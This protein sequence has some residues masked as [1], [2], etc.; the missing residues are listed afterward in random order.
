MILCSASAFSDIELAL[1]DPKWE[2]LLSNNPFG[3]TS[4]QVPASESA[5]AQK[6]QPLLAEKNHQAILD[7]FST[8][9]VDKDSAALRQLRGQMLLSMKRNDEAKVALKKAL[10]LMPDL[11]TAHQSLSMVYLIDKEYRKAREHLSRAIELGASNAELYGQL[12]FVHTQLNQPASAIAG[13]QYALFLDPD[14]KHWQ[15]GLLFALSSA[16]AYDQ[17]L[18]LIE[19]MLKKSPRDAQLWLRRGQLA[20]AQD[21]KLMA[22]SSMEAALDLGENNVANIATT[23][24]LHLQSGS[25][26]RAVTLLSD[27]MN[28]FANPDQIES[29]SQIAGWFAYQ[30][31]WEKLNKLIVAY[32]DFDKN[33]P[34]SYRAQFEVYQA[35][36]A[37]AKHRLKTAAAHFEAALSINPNSGEALLGAAEILRAQK[38]ENKAVMYYVRAQALASFKERALLGRAQLEIDR[39]NYRE[40]L[41]ALRE[42]NTMTPGRG[43]ILANIRSLENLVRNQG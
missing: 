41:R 8:R 43:D 16:K 1:Q 14:N 38:R 33:I 20:L 5:F 3:A 17:A 7:A 29:L 15:Q 18:A 34:D 25:P 11:V 37:L 2:F 39:Q 24:Q 40:A 35:Q 22:L 12:G 42:V 6:L 21:H 19:E 32:R 9:N 13:Y 30:E 31:D 10:E 36:I 4:A 27:N 28:Q 23:A 26:D